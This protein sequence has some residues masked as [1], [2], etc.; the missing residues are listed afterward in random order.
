MSFRLAVD[1]QQNQW[2]FPKRVRILPGVPAEFAQS[3]I[4][5]TGAGFFQT[6][7]GTFGELHS[8]FIQCLIIQHGTDSAGSV[9]FESQFLPMSLNGERG[10]LG[11]Q[12]RSLF[13]GGS[14]VP[15]LGIVHDV[16]VLLGH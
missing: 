4:Q 2:C 11:G 5:R 8:P 1:G 7:P 6:G 16:E 9:F 13:A 14:Q 15:V 12:R 3:D 10:I